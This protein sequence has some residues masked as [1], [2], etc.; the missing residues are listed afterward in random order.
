MAKCRH[1]WLF[2]GG[3]KRSPQDEALSVLEET[4]S[5][6]RD[7]LAGGIQKKIARGTGVLVDPPYPCDWAPRLRRAE[8]E[9]WIEMIIAPHTAFWRQWLTH[10][11]C[12]GSRILDCLTAW[13]SFEC[14][15]WRI[16]NHMF[17]D[18]VSQIDSWIQPF[19]FWTMMHRQ[20][21]QGWLCLSHVQVGFKANDAWWN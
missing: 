7:E 6:A 20:W 11:E 18:L 2:V 15:V 4:W 19:S 16:F 1:C 5:E 14:L 8:H 12:C 17:S 21:W 10:F 13:K 3:Q 9:W